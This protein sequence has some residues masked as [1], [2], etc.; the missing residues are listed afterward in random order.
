MVGEENSGVR[1]GQATTVVNWQLA[2][3]SGSLTSRTVCRCV[4]VFFSSHCSF[5]GFYYIV[6]QVTPSFGMEKREE[7]NEVDLVGNTS[8]VF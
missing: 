2:A 3:F 6:L 7:R 5:S 1:R 8:T 4:R